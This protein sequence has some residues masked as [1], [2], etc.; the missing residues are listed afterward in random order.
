MSMEPPSV[1]GRPRSG[2]PN[3]HA[4]GPV[5][6]QGIPGLRRQATWIIDAVLADTAPE[7]ARARVLLRDL[8]TAHPERPEDALAEHL[9]A[10][11]STMKL[12]VEAEIRLSQAAAAVPLQIE[13]ILNGRMLVTAF[14]PI[15]ELSTGTVVGGQGFTRFVSDGGD[16]AGEWFTA[17]AAARLD[18]ELEFAALECALAAARYLPARLHVAL[19]LSPATCLHPLLPGLIEE[20]MPA[21]NRVV[22]QLTDA[23]T[24]DQPAAL[25]SA[26]APLRRRG[27]RLAVDHVG[28]YR[29]SITH[30]RQLG[31]DII[32]LDRDLVAGI[33]TD[34]LRHA[35]GGAMTGFAEQLGA[36]L[37][38]EGIETSGELAAVAALG[39]TVGQGYFLGRPSIRPQDWAGWNEP[40]LGFGPLA[41]ADGANDGG[42]SVR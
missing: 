32:K 7:Q 3:E 20:S 23:L 13:K 18:S 10:R 11:S 9:L 27:V 42:Q 21:L 24:P 37:I 15:R 41:E 36:L 30:I 39:V 16:A 5:P 31:P 22:L 4:S 29:E 33:D 2:E 14:Q 17:A 19:K 12:P 34:S 38:A 26:L 28:S 35:F 6:D 8:L 40:G 25:A 1:P